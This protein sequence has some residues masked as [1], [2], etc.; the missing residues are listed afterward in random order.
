MTTISL[1][2]AT[3]ENNCIGINNTMP[4]HIPEDFKHFKEVTMGKPCIMGRKTYESIL[5]QLGKPLPGRTSIVVSRSGYEHEGALSAASLEEAIEK[6]KSENTD[7][8]MIIG[9]AQ[10]YKQA[11]ENNLA[12]R[13]YLTR[14]HKSYDGDAFFPE[15]DSVWY[16]A[17]KDA[18]DEYSFVTLER[19]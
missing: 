17:K 11:L 5:D 13:I 18:R 15:L 14:V 2:V 19:S 7:E 9:G 10:I 6:A 12:S 4:W 1:I 3:A 8:V 16:E